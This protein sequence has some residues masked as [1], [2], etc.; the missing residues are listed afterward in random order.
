M[1]LCL[2]SVSPSIKQ[3]M[4][5]NVLWEGT[6]LR[7]KPVLTIV[8][9]Q[10][11]P[12]ALL[13]PQTDL[14]A[15]CVIEFGLNYLTAPGNNLYHRAWVSRVH[16]SRVQTP[17]PEPPGIHGT[18]TRSSVA[19]NLFLGAQNTGAVNVDPVLRMRRPRLRRTHA[20][21]IQ[22]QKEQRQDWD[23]HPVQYCSLCQDAL[24]CLL[25]GQLF[26]LGAS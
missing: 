20:E 17:P 25:P 2:A 21:Q 9:L 5:W 8:L 26:S 18:K 10:G 19:L 22:S 6:V 14:G 16:G 13:G 3:A 4:F 7:T 23:P 11:E 15:W 1:L 12:M 24:P